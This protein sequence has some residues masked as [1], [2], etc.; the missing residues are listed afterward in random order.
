[1][2][3]YRTITL[4][5]VVDREDSPGVV[6]ATS[7]TI[8][9]GRW[10]EPKQGHEAVCPPPA[11]PLWIHRVRLPCRHFDTHP[12]PRVAACS[13]TGMHTTH[14]SP[15]AG[16]RASRH[17]ERERL[18]HTRNQRHWCSGLDLPDVSRSGFRQNGKEGSHHLPSLRPAVTDDRA[19]IPA[20]STHIRVPAR[21]THR[22]AGNG[23]SR[24]T[25]GQ[26]AQAASKVTSQRSFRSRG[27]P[28]APLLKLPQGCRRRAAIGSIADR[29]SD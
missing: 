5:T 9:S 13:T 11:S 1:M 8:H 19:A 28:P 27:T 24:R 6:V 12:W 20:L 21:D 14:E 10:S 15:S 2:E 18:S 7:G 17:V 3:Y 4:W 26:P 16:C 25:D 23:S 22:H 29:I